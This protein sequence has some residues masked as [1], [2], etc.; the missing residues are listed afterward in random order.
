MQTATDIADAVREGSL[1]ATQVLEDCIKRINALN[2]ELNA[3]VYLDFEQAMRGAEQIDKRVQAGDDPGPLAGV[4]FGVKDLEDCRD[5]PTCNGSLFFRDAAPAENDSVNVARLRAAGA[6]PVGKTATAEF[7][8]DSATRT[9]TF[10]VTRNPWDLDRTPGGSSGGSAAAV[11]AGLTPICTASDGGGS[12]RAPASFTGLVGFKASQGRV[13][14][15]HGFHQ[16]GCM[17]ILSTSV[18]ETARYLDVAS[19]PHPGDRMSLPHEDVVYESAIEQL[20]VKGL[21]AI[22]SDDLGFAAVEKEVKQIARKAA[23][24]LINSAALE[25]LQDTVTL[26]NAFPAWLTVATDATRARLLRERILPDNE[27]KLS[28]G[29]RWAL[30]RTQGTTAVDLSHCQDTFLELEK[31]VAQLFE[32]SDLL[33]TPAVA[34]RAFSAEGPL[35]EQIEGQDASQSLAE[36]FGVFANICWNPSISIPAG[37]TKD[38]L[39]VGLQITGRRHQ[40]AILLRLARIFEVHRPWPRHAPAYE[41]IELLA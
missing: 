41:N 5:M 1:T 9:F 16:F 13:P 24:E 4:P 10:G 2:R 26:P 8:M 29:V 25:L 19:G 7:G 23:D 37:V 34:C 31:S 33:L 35:P 6:I 20:E 36:P 39:P 14:N 38:G 12:I 32:K 18:A 27:D 3:F 17:G 28:A 40:D 21:R 15:P 22:W 11:A 30:E